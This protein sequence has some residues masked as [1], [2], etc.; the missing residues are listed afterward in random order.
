MILDVVVTH[1]FRK[2]GEGYVARG[3]KESLRKAAEG[4]L[5]DYEGAA[6]QYRII[7]VAFL[8]LGR[9]A[10]LAMV[11]VRRAARRRAMGLARRSTLNVGEACAAILRKWREELAVLLAR[12]TA[13]TILAAL[14]ES[15]GR[16]AEAGRGSERSALEVL[17][18]LAAGGA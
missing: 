7:P 5:K 10:R 12:G 13:G 2:E 3:A 6:E 9:M 4:K 11:V 16:G 15:S 14:G 17:P 18:W 1:P 8:T